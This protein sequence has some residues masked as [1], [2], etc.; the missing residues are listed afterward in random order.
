VHVGCSGWNYRDWRPLVYPRG[1][2]GAHWL[3]R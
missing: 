3:E 1:L 2:P